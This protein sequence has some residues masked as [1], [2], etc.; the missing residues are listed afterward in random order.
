M[1]IVGRTFADNANTLEMP[2]YA[3]VN[4]SLQWKPDVNTT[5]SLR[6]WNLFDKIYATSSYTDNQW[7][8]GMPRT[9][10]L[11]VNVKF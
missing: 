2:S 7:M 8:L 4:A 9:A 3:L 10:Q 11:A 1:Q 6:V 5:V